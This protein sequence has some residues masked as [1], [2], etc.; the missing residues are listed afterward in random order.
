M[1]FSEF[2]DLVSAVADKIASVKSAQPTEKDRELCGLQSWIREIRESQW[3]KRLS[4]AEREKALR[5]WD[6]ANDL[7][8][9]AV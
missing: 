8:A 6:S 3:P 4:D 9:R 7:I 2:S 5:V 1:S